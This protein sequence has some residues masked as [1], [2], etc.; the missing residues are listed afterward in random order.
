MTINADTLRTLQAAAVVVKN[1]LT[2]AHKAFVKLPSATN[3][4]VCLRAMFT[5]QQLEYAIRSH[6]VDREK[7]AFDLTANP[8][9]EWQN[10]VCRAT[11]GSDIK[12]ALQE[13]AVF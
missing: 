8:Q 3:W 4:Q 13:F 6:I 2:A 1:A 11:L 9:G 12:D 7:L 5:H 10:I